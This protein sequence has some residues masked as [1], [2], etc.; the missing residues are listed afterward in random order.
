MITIGKKNGHYDGS[1]VGSKA[2]VPGCFT[3]DNVIVEERWE[4]GFKK[5]DEVTGIRN[6]VKAGVQHFEY[7][8]YSAFA[9]PE[10]LNK[11]VIYTT[12]LGVDKK[13]VADCNRAVTI[14]RHMKVKW[15]ER[16]IFISDEHRIDFL[17]RRGL[18][19][20]E[21]MVG[22]LPAIY[23]DG[24]YVGGFDELEALADC[25]DLRVRLSEFE[26]LYERHKCPDCKGL[27]Q[28]TCNSC[29]GKKV[30]RRNKF[31]KL[32]CGECDTNGQVDCKGCYVPSAEGNH[33]I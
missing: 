24:Q 9:K 18:G 26:K 6:R 19:N 27:G 11:V 2:C 4:G 16:D 12:T 8:L 31:G 14:I 10:D 20:G 32:K 5:L 22:H 17:K 7:D 1:F 33:R 15:E 25:G 3:G 13:L 21:S 29:K 23:I 30:K 28:L